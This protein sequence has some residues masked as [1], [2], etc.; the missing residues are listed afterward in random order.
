MDRFCQP[1]GISGEDMIICILRS[2]P[3]LCR[4]PS[5][6][7]WKGAGMCGGLRV[8]MH[9]IWLRLAGKS[10]AAEQDPEEIAAL[11]PCDIKHCWREIHILSSPPPPFSPLFPSPHYLPVS[12]GRHY[13]HSHYRALRH[14]APHPSR[15]VCSNHVPFVAES[16]SDI[17]VWYTE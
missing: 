11:L 10:S 12:H 1:K 5:L 4:I 9:L 8:S 7:N 6:G 17:R 14:P 15:W 13:H 3:C 16:T 2:E